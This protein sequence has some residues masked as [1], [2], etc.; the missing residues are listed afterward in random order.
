MDG[1]VLLTGSD[2]LKTATFIQ[3]VM[4]GLTVSDFFS[5]LFFALIGVIISLL[6]HAVGRD[7]T[8]T[9]TPVKFSF[10]FLL[11]DNWKRI[12]LSLLLIVVTIRFLP[13]LTG[14]KFNMFYALCIGLA[15]D[16]LSEY[17]KTKSNI[18]DVPR[19]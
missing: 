1:Y 13:D 14:L 3:N 15:W 8:S 17:I 5:A 19:Q 7:L 12:L 6:M 9:T 4:D 11:K 10:K 16:K 18:L 2:S